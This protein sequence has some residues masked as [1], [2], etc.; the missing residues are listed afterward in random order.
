MITKERFAELWRNMIE[1]AKVTDPDSEYFGMLWKDAVK[2]I[3]D[4]IED[5]CSP[6]LA[7]YLR[8]VANGV[9]I[10]E[11]EEKY[12]NFSHHTRDLKENGSFCIDSFSSLRY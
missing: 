3:R 9:P 5:T 12:K 1:N 10:P 6:H 8:D 4:P 7:D 11:L 2:L